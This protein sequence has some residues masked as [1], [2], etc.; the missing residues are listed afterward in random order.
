M[1][2][3]SSTEYYDWTNLHAFQIV[4]RILRLDQ[5]TCFSDRPQNIMK[6]F[7]SFYDLKAL[8]LHFPHEKHDRRMIMINS[9]DCSILYPAFLILQNPSCYCI[10]KSCNSRLKIRSTKL[11]PM[12][13]SLSLLSSELNSISLAL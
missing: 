1:L 4:P 6:K 8:Y 11:T 10:T 3:R 7:Y 12:R 9:L 13:S 2:F 5:F